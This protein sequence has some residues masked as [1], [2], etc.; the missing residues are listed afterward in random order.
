MIPSSWLDH[1]PMKIV[2]SCYKTLA[3]TRNIN[4]WFG[5]V[6][7]TILVL[8]TSLLHPLHICDSVNEK[9]ESSALSTSILFKGGHLTKE[10]HVLSA[11]QHCPK[12][13]ICIDFF[14]AN[15]IKQR[16]YLQCAWSKVPKWSK[17]NPKMFFSLVNWGCLDNSRYCARPLLL[18]IIMPPLLLFSPLL[19]SSLP[20]SPLLSPSLPFSPLLSPSLLFSLACSRS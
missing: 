2:T 8:R 10:A 6:F 9:N 19:S 5:S 16:T 4:V 11:D 20:F 15:Q 13:D 3:N 18:E 14:L 17:T 12:V 7:H 1:L